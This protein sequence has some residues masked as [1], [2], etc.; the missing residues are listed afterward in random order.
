M[1]TVLVNEPGIEAERECESMKISGVEQVEEHSLT[2]KIKEINR[3]DTSIM[4]ANTLETN[5]QQKEN[6]NTDVFHQDPRNKEM[7]KILGEEPSRE[8]DIECLSMIK[9]D[10]MISGL[11]EDQVDKHSLTDEIEEN[12]IDDLFKQNGILENLS[13][14]LD[15]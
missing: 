6:G 12:G 3:E 13:K 1:N 8:E 14:Y 2:E 11:K 15:I 10:M 5:N 7:E 9:E 4:F